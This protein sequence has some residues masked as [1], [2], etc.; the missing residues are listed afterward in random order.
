MREWAIQR[1]SGLEDR[2]WVDIGVSLHEAIF[3]SEHER[4]LAVEE[5]FSDFVKHFWG[6]TNFSKDVWFV[7]VVVQHFI[8]EAVWVDKEVVV[9]N[10]DSFNLRVVLL[11][12][13][14]VGFNLLAWVVLSNFTF[15]NVSYSFFD[16][17]KLLI[18]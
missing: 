18:V 2:L 15:L 1:L 8:L 13:I 5:V 3:K 14:F 6:L 4:R 17:S 10:Y 7:C 9:G 12:Q 11:G 16:R